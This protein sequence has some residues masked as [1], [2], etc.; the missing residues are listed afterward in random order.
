MVNKQV[1]SACAA[2]GGAV[3]A[4]TLGIGC[5]VAGVCGV[6]AGVAD[7]AKEACRACG[8]GGGAGI[9]VDRLTDLLSSNTDRLSDEMRNNTDRLSEQISRNTD[10]LTDEMRDNTEKL[11][12]EMRDNTERLFDEIRENTDRLIAK[13]NILTLSVEEVIDKSLEIEGQI[14]LTQIIALYGQDIANYQ[15]VRN[16][17]KRLKKNSKGLIMRNSDAQRFEQAANDAID[18][19]AASSMQI[20]Q[21]MTGGHP[22]KSE[23]IFQ[24]VPD[25]CQNNAKEYF[26]KVM[27]DC[28]LL[29]N[30]ARAMTGE[31]MHPTRVQQFKRQLILIEDQ[32]IR[33]CGCPE[34]MVK[35]TRQ[36]GLPSALASLARSLPAGKRHL[37]IFS[38]SLCLIR[39]LLMGGS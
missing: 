27:F 4:F 30:V 1:A 35:T 28:Y 3:C 25:F 38:D 32:F 10:R 13:I 26:L 15:K 29:E 19:L 20:F 39:P 11:S 37:F 24:A 12:D 7:G 9:D 21:M 31:S 17:F 22:L 14:Q 23:S 33:S 8:V 5:I 34:H 2:V 6:A 18:G 16:V 36:P